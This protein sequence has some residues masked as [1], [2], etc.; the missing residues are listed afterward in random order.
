MK[1]EDIPF[2]EQMIESIEDSLLSLEKDF[3]RK[4]YAGY[5]KSRKFIIKAKKY[6]FLRNFSKCGLNQWPPI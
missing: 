5:N 3:D 4:D 2:L 1:K 6:V